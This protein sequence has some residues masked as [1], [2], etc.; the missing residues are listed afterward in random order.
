VTPGR[1][2]QARP[3]DGSGGGCAAALSRY[4]KRGMTRTS[5]PAPLALVPGGA[6]GREAM[7]RQAE[8]GLL[9]AL[10]AGVARQD[11]RA[12]KALYDATAPKL[13]GIVLR[14]VRDRAVAEEVLQD[15]F[16]RV[17]QNAAT[18]APEAGQ[19]L[20]WLAS[21]ARYR[22]IDVVR[23]R[24]EIAIGSSEEGDDWVESIV[25]LRDGE[26]ELIDRDRL[27]H[28]LGRLEEAQRTCLVL[29]YCE[30]F[31]R[32]ELAARY[33][34]PVNTIKTWLHRGLLSLRGC[35]DEIG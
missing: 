4:N 17:W 28:C 34:R 7:G 3:A 21:V 13:F 10:I 11:R 14:I 6:G 1:A 20:T 32:E 8:S 35:L 16:L 12:F 2:A 23:R 25:D 18:Y 22:A 9:A 29:A 33:G 31:S 30:G 5:A 24:R 19:P 26:A 15:V 27:R